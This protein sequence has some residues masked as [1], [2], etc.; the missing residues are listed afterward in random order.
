MS[1]T[2]DYAGIGGAA[3]GGIG[4]F[5]S[6][7]AQSDGIAAGQQAA[8]DATGKI[9]A[10]STKAKNENDGYANN[11]FTAANDAYTK[12]YGSAISNYQGMKDQYAPASTAYMNLSG[13]NGT[14]ARDSATNDMFSSPIYSAA[15]NQAQQQ[16]L[17]GQADRGQL[18]SGATAAD[19]QT[20]MMAQGNQYVNQ[21]LQNLQ[22]L[23]QYGNQ[24][25]QNLSQAQI[26]QGG[27]LAGN[28][29]QLG[30]S[31]TTNN[32]NDVSTQSGA[33]LAK[34]KADQ[35]AA[36][37]NANNDSGGIGGIGSAIGSV[38]GFL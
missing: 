27:A 13:A 28:N 8:T 17:Q 12:G 36:S 18:N 23:L 35:A 3:V 10:L 32:N 1:D 29:W 5:L 34:M 7:N 30:N 9:S 2:T 26:G 38:L 6:A 21:N 14:Q 25:N 20:R 31:L 33:I 22:P 16:V 11:A 19:L 24:A 4:S 37:A 15:S